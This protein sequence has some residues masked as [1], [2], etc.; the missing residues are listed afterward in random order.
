MINLNLTFLDDDYKKGL[1][2]IEKILHDAGKQI[3]S[4]ALGYFNYIVSSTEED[5]IVKE[6]VLY[7]NVP[8]IAYDYRV[9]TLRYIDVATVEVIFHTLS[10]YS[11]ITSKAIITRGTKD[12]EQAIEDIF[13]TSAVNDTFKFLVDEVN[14]NRKNNNDGNDDS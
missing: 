11:V 1:D 10:T 12:L 3:V 4:Y 2:I 14:K 13:H 5:G 6:S 9:V 7:L 8:E